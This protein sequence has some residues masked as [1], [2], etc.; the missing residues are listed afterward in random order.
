[1]R[2]YSALRAWFLTFLV[3]FI[4]ACDSKTSNGIQDLNQ[5][6]QYAASTQST[7]KRPDQSKR[8]TAA[9]FN[10]THP[11]FTDGIWSFELQEKECSAVKYGDGRGESDCSNGNLR[12][13]VKAPRIIYPGQEVEYYVEL[14]VDPNFRYDGGKTLSW[15]KLEIAEWGR[16]EG[17][18][19]H[20]YDL[21]LDTKRGLTFERTVCVPPSQ[22]S[23]WNS[24]RLNIKWAKN[25]DGYLEARCNGK[26]VL[27][28][29]SQQTVIPPDCAE[30]YKEQCDPNKQIPEAGIYWHVGPKLSGH[31][32]NYRSNGHSSHFSVFPT[33]GIKLEMRSLYQGDSSLN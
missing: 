13:R 26:V 3:I 28:R 25:G 12:S 5:I 29:Q 16:V 14:R 1:M 31:G 27:S 33:N 17:V 8:F 7:S 19:N 6:S 2:G 15:S 11:K 9:R 20:I 18:K 22:L 21:Q 24:F 32:S 23:K 10:G 4:S 30:R